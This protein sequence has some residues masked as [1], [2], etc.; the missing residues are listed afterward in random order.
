VKS[1]WAA[2]DAH[3]QCFSL[4]FQRYFCVENL[5]FWQKAGF[6]SFPGRFV[7]TGSQRQFSL[8]DSP[9][10]GVSRARDLKSKIVDS[11]SDTRMVS[12]LQ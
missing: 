11:F 12:V 2:L 1:L 9:D 8:H 6:P 3:A 10:S 4:V 7:Y 5:D